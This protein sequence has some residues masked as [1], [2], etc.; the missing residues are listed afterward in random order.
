MEGGGNGRRGKW[1]EGVRGERGEGGNGGR[2]KWGEG[3]MWEG[4]MGGEGDGRGGKGERGNEEWERGEKGNGG[5]LEVK[6]K[7]DA[8][9]TLSHSSFETE[10]QILFG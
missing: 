3:E 8:T 2:G 9:R 4:E 10:F 7:R 5:G 6:T 1:G